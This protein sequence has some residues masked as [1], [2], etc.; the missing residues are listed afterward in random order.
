MLGRIHKLIVVAVLTV[1]IASPW[2]LLQT[3]AWAGMLVKFS[4]HASFTAAISLTFDGNH[5]CALCKEIQVSKS[6]ERKETRSGWESATRDL[7]LDFPPQG[8]FLPPPPEFCLVPWF[9][10]ALSARADPP[11]VPP[12]RLA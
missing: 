7:K 12:P 11:P 9:L 10:A 8:V 1:S 3:L 4:R 5:P 2:A 6:K